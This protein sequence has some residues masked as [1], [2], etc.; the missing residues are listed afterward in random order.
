MTIR[1]STFIEVIPILFGLKSPNCSKISSDFFEKSLVIEIS[2][3]NSTW[4]FSK[5]SRSS[6]S[7]AKKSEKKTVRNFSK[8]NLSSASW[9]TKHEKVALN[10][11]FIIFERT[12]KNVKHIN[13]DW[14]CV[15]W[16]IC[17]INLLTSMCSIVLQPQKT[18]SGLAL[19]W[20]TFS[21][22]DLGRWCQ[23]LGPWTTIIDI[24]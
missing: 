24:K 18:H 7:L 1:L 20:L 14:I 11:C 2:T 12:K 6:S 4:S 17:V 9:E 21:N 8:T 22:A 15:I 16:F 13:I 5:R 3:W 10:I 19:A 23:I